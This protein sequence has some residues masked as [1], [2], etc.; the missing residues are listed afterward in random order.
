MKKI[1]KSTIELISSE[2][3]KYANSISIKELV[4]ILEIANHHYY[5]ESKII[6]EDSVYDMLLFVL[7]ERDPNN[8]LLVKV[9]ILD[10]NNEVKLPYPMYSLNKITELDNIKKELHSWQK[11]YTGPYVI[12]DKLDGVSAQIIKDRN[13]NVKLY[14]RGDGTSGQDISHLVKHLTTSFQLEHLEKGVSLRG[15]IVM[16]KKALKKLE[17]TYAN[18]R[19]AI[20]GLV[21]AKKDNYNHNT[22]LFARLV[23]YSVINPSDMNCIQMMKYIDKIGFE[24]VWNKTIDIRDTRDTPDIED[25][26]RNTLEKRKEESLYDI[27]GIVCVDSSKI[28]KLGNK[29]PKHAFAFKLMFQDQIAETTVR[30]IIWEPSMYYYLN[31]T[32]IFDEVL[33][34]GSKINK[35]TAHNAKYVKENKIGPGTKIK[36]IKSGDVIPY[37]LSVIKPSKKAQM[38]NIKYK[39][40]ESKVDII[41]SSPSTEILKSVT[42]RR[43]EHFFKTLKIKYISKAT[44]AKIYDK[45]YT[46]IFKILLAK[47]TKLSKIDGLGIKSV[48]KIFEGIAK[49]IK[50]T[51]LYVIMAASLEFGRNFGSRRIKMIMDKYPLIMKMKNT[52]EDLIKKIQNINGFSEITSVQFVSNLEKF[53][54]YFKK[55]E[56]CIDVS[57]LYNDKG[58]SS[59]E[60]CDIMKGKTIV[61][62]GFRD[63]DLSEKIVSCGG[64]ITTSISKNTSIVVYVPDTKTKSSKLLKAQKLFEELGIPLIMTKDDFIKKIDI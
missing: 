20:S 2:P 50:K 51:K 13:G 59:D 10:D 57:Y 56:K 32:L 31:P 9:G 48:D 38:P 26:L 30:K 19:S 11:K 36:I 54:E 44:I 34:K 24:S 47:K 17:Q 42:V 27:D 6:I 18:G 33:I 5:R 29:N 21:G 39:W 63:D 43:I 4:E 62:T 22:A 16:P 35:A 15:E 45:G 1:P 3:F 28:Y 46:D 55:L 37:I 64:K 49:A 23:I 7:K 8:S 41:A 52:N 25:I 61:F 58:I 53:K 40:T 60:N 14:T 12:S